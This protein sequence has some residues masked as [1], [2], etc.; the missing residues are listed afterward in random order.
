MITG[1]QLRDALISGANNI[2]KQK[3]SVDEL[4]IFPVPDGDTGTNMSM[5]MLAAA[6]ELSK[7]KEAA[8]AGNIASITA[9]AMLRGARGNSGVILSL[10]FRGFSKGL[11]GLEEASGAD[12]ANALAIGVEA[13]YKAVMN[14][15]EGTIL[16]VSR[17]AAEKGRAAAIVNDDPVYVWE[18][19]CQGAEEALESTPDLLPVL[20]KA[21]VVDAGGKG[22]II[23]FRGMMSVFR[24]GVMIENTSAEDA[25]LADEAFR[26]AAAEFDQEI[27][28][29][30][31]TEFIVGR[32]PQITTE[33]LELRAYL[34]TIGDCVLVVDDDEIIKVHVHTNNPGNALQEGLKFGQLLTVKIENMEEQH[35]AAAQANEGK[36]AAAVVDK[37][38]LDPV[39]PTEETGFVAVAAGN[40]LRTLFTDLGCTHVVSGGQTMN[41]STEDLLAAVKA[42][43][44][45]TVYILPNNKN[46]ILAAE[47]TVQL[48]DDRNVVV[49]PT[50]TIPQGLAAMLTF[51]P[52]LEETENTRQMTEAASKVSTGQVTFAARDS[53]F[54][55][56]RI[57]QGDILGLENGVLKIVDHEDIIK[58]AAK[59]TRGMISRD[60]SFVTII[61]GEDVSDQQAE[62]LLR[63]VESK[64]GEH[65]EITLVKGEQ[66]VYYF[67]ISVE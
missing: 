50:K 39:E 13:S 26:N 55:G 2:A 60:S 28:F 14:P 24:D 35:R 15:T 19:V 31:C 1:S 30:Y 62:E 49:L 5:T 16:T 46:I 54:G 10:L 41:P 37:K 9:S 43:P 20:K 32:D 45:K 29:T 4:N 21:G 12:M 64:A 57:K 22:L 18:A 17:I 61:Y 56:F 6:K 23:I 11:A 59:I 8:A 36:K 63:L 42:T 53:E 25:G 3:T 40:G 67:I 27:N 33:P 48:C 44:A 58:V 7:N 38:S 51:D 66:P 47:Q 34:E 52:D 65:V